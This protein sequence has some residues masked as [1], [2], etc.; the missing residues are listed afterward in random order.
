MKKAKRT[1]KR[2]LARPRKTSLVKTGRAERLLTRAEFL[3][4]AEV[5][6]EMEWFANIKNERTKRAYKIDVED[7][8]RFTGIERPEDFRVVTRSHV[9]AWRKDLEKRDLGASTIRRKL[10]ALSSLFQ[11]LCE[12]NAVMLNPVMGV[13]RPGEGS[14]EGKTPA[15]GDHEARA[16][17]DSPSPETL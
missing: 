3:G 2:E 9:I 10:S 7:F 15:L 11:Y 16:L 13:S 12:A 1:T 17:L 4:L 8:V 14:N 5:P 6:P